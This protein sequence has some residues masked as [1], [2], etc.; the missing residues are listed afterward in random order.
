MSDVNSYVQDFARQNEDYCKILKNLV[1]L[2]MIDS[3]L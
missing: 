1:E 2:N 3:L